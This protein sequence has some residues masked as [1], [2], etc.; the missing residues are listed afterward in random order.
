MQHPEFIFYGICGAASL[1][2]L[3]AYEYRAKLNLKKFQ[4]LIRSP[5]F[6][7]V[8]AGM[9]LAS[10]FIAWAANVDRTEVRIWEVVATGIA[11]RSIIRDVFA[12]KE[13][14]K[15]TKLGNDTAI[16]SIN[17]KDIFL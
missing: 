5:L 17:M 16:D 2:M 7:S 4:K 9:L 13:A 12:S 6:W 15:P 3:K 10:G 8:V 14:S 11:A 1:E